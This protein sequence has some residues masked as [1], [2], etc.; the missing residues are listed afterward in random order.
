VGGTQ[1]DHEMHISSFDFTCRDCHFGVVHNPST[2]TDR[3]NFCLTCHA[4]NKDSSAPQM[5]DCQACHQAQL[6]MNE[7]KGA[8]GVKGETGLMFAA[9]IGCTDCHTGVTKGVYRPSATSCTDCHEG[10]DYV[11]LYKEWAAQTKE[12]TTKL[13]AQRVEVE[14]AL[15][16]ADA[17]NRNTGDA[18]KLY[19]R[20]LHNLRF[21]R[22]DGTN[23][24]HNSDFAMT[25]LD[26]VEADF[27]QVMKQLDTIW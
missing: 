12:K 21:V 20:A 6:A 27:K 22:N 25:I 3:M 19:Q 14:A 24:V 26:S 23:G 11:N 18:W 16:D 5:N 2:K 10:E 13:Q 7:G 17:A 8:E 15:N 1:F 9:G 4:E